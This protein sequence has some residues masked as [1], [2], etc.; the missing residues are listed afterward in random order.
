MR[1]HASVRVSRMTVSSSEG[2]DVAVIQFFHIFEG[3]IALAFVL[4]YLFFKT[5]VQ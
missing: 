3:N 1:A 2:G 5:V 4:S